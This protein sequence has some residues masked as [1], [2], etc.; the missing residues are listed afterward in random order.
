MNGSGALAAGW[1][2]LL[3]AAACA[4]VGALLG[5]LLDVRFIGGLA[6]G[7]LGTIAGFILVWHRY[8]VPANREDAARDYTRVRKFEDDD[9]DSW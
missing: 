1:L 4:A 7:V 9:D 5:G 8:V 3:T 6:G 2:L